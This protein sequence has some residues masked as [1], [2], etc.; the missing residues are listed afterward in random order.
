M[1]ESRKELIVVPLTKWKDHFDYPTQGTM[2]NVVARR[3]EN[4]A[5]AFLSMVNGRF[6]IHIEKFH[7]WME[8][9]NG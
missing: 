1:K 9:Q 3:K 4:G 7:K 5:E 6:Y 2:R 8:G